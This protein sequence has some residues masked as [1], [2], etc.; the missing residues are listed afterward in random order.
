MNEYEFKKLSDIDYVEEPVDGTTVMG[1]ENGTPVQMPMSAIKG[2]GN[3]FVIDR[4]S[5]EFSLNDATYGDRVKEAILSGKTCWYYN[6]THYCA[7]LYFIIS[8]NCGIPSMMIYYWNPNGS[9]VS[10][11]KSALNFKISSIE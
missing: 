10:S 1:L 11:L 9:S 3:V 4:T 5:T 8:V 6:G 2:D 7:I